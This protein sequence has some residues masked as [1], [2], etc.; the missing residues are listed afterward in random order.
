MPIAQTTPVSHML[1]ALLLGLTAAAANILGGLFAFSSAFHARPSRS[2]RD[3]VA[4]LPR[5]ARPAS[6]LAA[7][8]RQQ[9]DRNQWGVVPIDSVMLLI[10][11]FVSPCDVAICKVAAGN[12]MGCQPALPVR[13]DFA[14]PPPSSNRSSKRGHRAP[15][16]SFGIACRTKAQDCTLGRQRQDSKKTKAAEAPH[17][18]LVESLL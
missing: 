4:D 12:S 2:A 11:H 18:R 7:K 17:Q 8:D 15:A 10:N 13:K 1:L 5:F 9:I 14:K 6:S 16:R 3:V